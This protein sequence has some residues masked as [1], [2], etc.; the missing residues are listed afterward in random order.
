[1][2]CLLFYVVSIEMGF[3]GVLTRW[4]MKGGR[5]S[6]GVTKSHRRMGSMGGGGVS[7]TTFTSCIIFFS[8]N[9]HW[10][11]IKKK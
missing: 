2:T 6:H 1:M 10:H 3:Q 7:Y 8:S 11:L 9:I 4:G 5:A